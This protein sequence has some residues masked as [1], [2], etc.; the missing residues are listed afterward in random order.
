MVEAAKPPPTLLKMD[1]KEHWMIA[2]VVN[3][4]NSVA[5]Y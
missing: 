2:L 1:R 5:K 4:W 3:D